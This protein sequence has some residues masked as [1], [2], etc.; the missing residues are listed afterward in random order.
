MNKMYFVFFKLFNFT[1]IVIQSFKY[2]DGEYYLFFKPT[3]SLKK[4]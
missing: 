3:A 4:L 2:V 1:M